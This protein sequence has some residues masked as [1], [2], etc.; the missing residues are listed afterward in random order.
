[1]RKQFKNIPLGSIITPCVKKGAHPSFKR[2]AHLRKFSKYHGSAIK[3]LDD[4]E[5]FDC[6]DEQKVFWN[7]VKLAKG[8]TSLSPTPWSRF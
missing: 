3:R 1:M 6:R 8:P 5:I 4:G 7:I 2:T